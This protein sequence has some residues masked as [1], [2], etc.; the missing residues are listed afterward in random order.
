[1]Q[2]AENPAPGSVAEIVT[3]LQKAIDPATGEPYVRIRA[4]RPDWGGEFATLK[5]AHRRETVGVV[6]CGAPAI[7]AALKSA[8]DLTSDAV[9]GTLFRLHKE[10]F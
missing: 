6:F 7:A 1:M 5:E 9:E 2:P 3:E 10:N 4:G 8:C